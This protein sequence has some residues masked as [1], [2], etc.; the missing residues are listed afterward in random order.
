MRA[1][2][3]Y[4]KTASSACLHS[5][6]HRQHTLSGPA[7][8]AGAH[9]EVKKTYFMSVFYHKVPGSHK[10]NGQFALISSDDTTSFKM[11]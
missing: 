8:I 5:V 9:W 10:M 2:G 11:A 6:V 7:G 1:I 3:L 4:G